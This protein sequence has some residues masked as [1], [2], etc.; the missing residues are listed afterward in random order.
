MFTHSPSPTHFLCGSGK[1]PKQTQS[2][3]SEPANVNSQHVFFGRVKQ[4]VSV[5][6]KNIPVPFDERRCDAAGHWCGENRNLSEL[7]SHVD[8]LFA[9]RRFDKS[10]LS[11]FLVWGYF[12]FFLGG[13]GAGVY[14]FGF[15]FLCVCVLLFVGGVLLLISRFAEGIKSNGLVGYVHP[16]S[17]IGVRYCVFFWPLYRCLHVW[18]CYN[19]WSCFHIYLCTG[20]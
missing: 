11:A 13:G 9:A 14:F 19:V 18:S 2:Q 12:F 10:S 16:N 7:L 17:M 3:T 20:V 8:L 1:K 5:K 6:D 15:L 4:S